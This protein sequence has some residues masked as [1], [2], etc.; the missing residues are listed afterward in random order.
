MKRA[1]GAS[2]LAVTAA[3]V[4]TSCSSDNSESAGSQPASDATATAGAGET[5]YTEVAVGQPFQISNEEGPTATVTVVDIEIDPTC[6]TAY[7]TPTPPQGT[8]VALLLDVQTTANPPIKYISDAWFDE[9]TPDGYTKSIPSPSETCIADREHFT[10]DPAPNSKYRGWILLDVSNPG[11]SL[12][13]SDIW[14]GRTPPATYR[15]PIS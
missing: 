3:M 4:L 12:L 15:I 11:S 9:L 2:L 6:T 5:A 14:D 10:S 7:G 8:N 1:G 13:M